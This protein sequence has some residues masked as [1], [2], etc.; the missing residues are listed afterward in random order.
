MRP[1]RISE[2][3]DDSDLRIP[4]YQRPYSWEPTTALRL[5]DDIAE[6]YEEASRDNVRRS[7]VMGSVILHRNDGVYDVVDGQQRLLTLRMVAALLNPVDD[8]EL[9]GDEE[10][11]VVLAWAS[12]RRR[13][14]PLPEEK[15][16]ELLSFM[17]N[18]C[19]VVRVETDE[20]DEAFRVFDSQNYRG[21]PLAPHDLLKAHHLREM[22]DDTDAMKAAVVEVWESADDADLDRLF[23]TY[24]Y[25]ISRW[26]RG[27]SA[28]GFR[29]QDIGMFKGISS[30]RVATPSARYHLAAQAAVP[31][32]G[33]WS[34]G[35]SR[36]R[37]NSRTRFQLDAPVAAGRPFFEFVEFMLSEVT[38]LASEA[39]AG[40]AANFG[41]YSH[42]ALAARQQLIELSSRARYRYVSEL[43]VAALLYYT[44][45]FGD[46]KVDEARHALFSWAYSLRVDLSRVQFRSIDNRARGQGD[47]Q[48]AFGLIR[49]GQSSIALHQLPTSTKP[50]REGHEGSLVEYIKNG[51]NA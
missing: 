34:G 51:F 15:R 35:D 39:F 21:K 6:A 46:E 45:K 43:Y 9:V 37:E 49:N 5:V 40:P 3:L 17:L 10:S 30:S 50:Y 14:L 31:M 36:S 24:L 2:L 22:R 29:T 41:V 33:A 26:S 8:F 38:Q 4:A 44:N 1:V 32:L 7:Y 13:L 28:P 11:P 42:D 23:S 48:T 20:P 16:R 25:R 19:E 12:L 18:R 47:T 27:E